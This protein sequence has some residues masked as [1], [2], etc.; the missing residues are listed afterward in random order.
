MRGSLAGVDIRRHSGIAGRRV[1]CCTQHGRV[2][3]LPI[4]RR[5]VPIVCMLLNL[6]VTLMPFN[7]VHAHVSSRDQHE[8]GVHGGHS[9]QLAHSHDSAHGHDGGGSVHPDADHGHTHAVDHSHDVDHGHD[10]AG[11]HEPAEVDQ[12]VDLKPS[13]TNQNNSSSVSALSLHWLPLACVVAV[14]SDGV[15]VC[16][17]LLRPPQSSSQPLSH[18]GYWRPPLR[19]PPSILAH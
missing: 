18:R 19:G 7:T 13:L 11:G 12:V 8:T 14:L 3:R 9:H 17:S 10:A 15:Q 16:I 4:V 1:S 5:F 6:S 2:V